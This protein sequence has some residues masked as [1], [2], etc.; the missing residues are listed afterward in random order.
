MAL[1]VSRAVTDL[2]YRYRMPTL[3]PM[4]EDK[5]NGINTVI[6]N[7]SDIAKSLERPQMCRSD[8]CFGCKLGA[9]TDT[10][11]ERYIVNV[12]H[13]AAKLQ[14]VLGGFIK[15]FVLCPA[16]DNLETASVSCLQ[17]AITRYTANAKHAGMHSLLIISRHNLSTCILKN[18]PKIE[19]DFFK[20]NKR[21]D[22]GTVML[23]LEKW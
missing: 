9:Q 7:K 22:N 15:K 2:F 20:D 14:E 13:D 23:G 5:G 12:E 3:L 1:N 10:K 21:N 11:N 17:C 16:C 19:V 4:V 6:A 18:P 8:K